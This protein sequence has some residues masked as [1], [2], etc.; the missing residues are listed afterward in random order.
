MKKLKLLRLIALL[1]FTI[2]I[3]ISASIF[4]FHPTFASIYPH[5]FFRN[6]VDE[7]KIDP[8][9]LVPQNLSTNKANEI[10][11]NYSQLWEENL[12]KGGNWIHLL[13][14]IN[15][16]VNNGVV[17]PD[18]KPMPSSYL[19]EGWYFIDE[20][21]YVEKNLVILKDESGFVYQQAAFLNNT[22]YNLTFKER[23]D[24]VEPY[25]LKL[26]RGFIQYL[27]DVNELKIPVEYKDITVDNKSYKEISFKEI[28]E[29]PIQENQIGKQIKSAEIIAHFDNQTNEMTMYRK[30][31][32][33]VDGESVLFEECNLLLAEVMPNAPSSVLNILENLK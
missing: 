6:N 2:L 19:E 8:T 23:T 25:K 27:L 16:E 12:L 5:L 24:N 18:G 15:S 22:E 33:F 14:Q 28:Y 32:K 30:I 20:N 9:V 13:Y 29:S 7:P 21:G 10:A 31:Y 3:V 1:L 26:D 11:Q 17:L 4:I